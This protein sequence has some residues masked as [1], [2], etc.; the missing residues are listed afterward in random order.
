MDTSFKIK[1]EPEKEITL[2]SFQQN[3]EK[4]INPNETVFLWNSQPMLSS[5]ELDIL[6]D[7]VKAPKIPDMFYGYNRF[8]ILFPRKCNFIYEINPIQMLDLSNYLLMNEVYVHTEKQEK[9]EK[10]GSGSNENCI[11]YKPS[12][13]KVQF[14]EK[15]KEIKVPD[16][17]ELEKIEATADC[18]YASSYM[19]HASKFSNHLIYK[20]YME[21]KLNSSNSDLLKGFIEISEGNTRI[22]REL[23]DENIPIERLIPPNPVIK[24]WEIPLYD[25]E[26]NDNGVTI[27]NFRFR[28]MS[29]C[30]FGL[31]RNYQRVDNVCVRMIDTRIFY[32]YEKD[33]I[34][35][36][37]QVK[38]A[39]YEELKKKGFCINSEWSLDHNQADIVNKFLDVKVHVKDRLIIN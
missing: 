30:F 36:D 31:L 21:N 39:S 2:S 8:Y 19:G 29:D 7:K 35:R 6:S 24:Y 5:K 11:Y 23:T 18:F 22:K 10:E 12:P 38:E 28:I 37:F 4:D 17:V 15:W 33:Y 32:S 16:N 9:D 26:L 25:D 20:Q 27:A 13:L 34:L 14:Y 1:I 3:N